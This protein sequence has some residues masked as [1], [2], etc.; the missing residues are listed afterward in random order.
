MIDFLHYQLM[1]SLTS[2]VDTHIDNDQRYDPTINFGKGKSVYNLLNY[3]I[4]NGLNSLP[5]LFNA[6][7]I[8][9][10]TN[11]IRSQIYSTINI[12]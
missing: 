12:K 4:E 6:I 3:S 9:F 5:A 11:Q 2:K 1:S 7:P 8:L 10:L